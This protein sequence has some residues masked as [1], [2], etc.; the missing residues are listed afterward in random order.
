MDLWNEVEFPTPV[1]ELWLF[2]IGIVWLDL[3]LTILPF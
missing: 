1:A 3:A 2:Y